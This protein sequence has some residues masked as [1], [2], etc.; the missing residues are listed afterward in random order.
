MSKDT[1]AIIEAVAEGLLDQALELRYEMIEEC[2]QSKEEQVE[3]LKDVLDGAISKG[4]Y[5]EAAAIAAL[6]HEINLN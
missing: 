1:C 3:W 2:S 4:E 6:L 5:S